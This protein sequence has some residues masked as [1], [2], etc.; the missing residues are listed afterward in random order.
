MGNNDSMSDMDISFSTFLF[1]N[2]S[3]SNR[4]SM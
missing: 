1:P 3:S 2:A 4:R